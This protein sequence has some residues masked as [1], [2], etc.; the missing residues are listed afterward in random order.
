MPRSRRTETDNFCILVIFAK[1]S[2]P[3]SYRPSA[4]SLSAVVA[5]TS[6]STSCSPSS[7]T[8]PVSSMRCKSS[9]DCANKPAEYSLG[10]KYR[11]LIG[12]KVHHSEVLGVWCDLFLRVTSCRREPSS[13]R[14]H[15][16]S[17]PRLDIFELIHRQRQ[18]KQHRSSG[19][20]GVRPYIQGTA[21]N[22]ILMWYECPVWPRRFWLTRRLSGA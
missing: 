6:S 18:S 11:M 4:S 15:V 16:I 20:N 10:T 1:S 5:A 22:F 2:S 17:Q 19:A 8:F 14:Q 12:Y 9:S 21:V 7:V 3:S 13:L